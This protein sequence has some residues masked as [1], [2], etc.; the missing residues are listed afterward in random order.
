MDPEKFLEKSRRKVRIVAVNKEGEEMETEVVESVRSTQKKVEDICEKG[1]A[2]RFKF[3]DVGRLAFD[4]E[5]T[6]SSIKVYYDGTLI[7]KNIIPDISFY[8][9]DELEVNYELN[10]H[11]YVSSGGETLYEVEV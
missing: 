11:A 8:P 5:G 2:G 3:K 4:K 10:V 7:S 1:D 9:S 6:V